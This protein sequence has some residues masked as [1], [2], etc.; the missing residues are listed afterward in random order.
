VLDEVN[1]SWVEINK[2]L[3]ELSPERFIELLKGL[4][5]LSQQNKAWLSA[6]L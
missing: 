5:D 4:H 2:Q 6:K 3:Q 1:M